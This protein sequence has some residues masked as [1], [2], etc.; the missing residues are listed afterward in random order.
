MVKKMFTGFAAGLVLLGGAYLVQADTI[1][2]TGPGP[3]SFTSAYILSA[4]Q[5]RSQWLAAEFNLDQNYY[6]TGLYGWMW[7]S[8]N[9][10]QNFTISIYGDGGDVP[11]STNL[12]YSN[13][14]TISGADG[15]ADWEGY[16]ITWTDSKG[17]TGQFLSA[18]TYWIAFE[19]RTGN[20]LN[21]YDGGMPYSAPNPLGNGAFNQTGTWVPGDL[22]MGVQIEGDP[23]APVPEPATMLLFGTGLVGLAGSR[24][25]RKK[26]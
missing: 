6:I 23:A 5:Q 9:S 22:S 17:N 20:Y 15:H 1:I 2:D 26:K 12:L 18:G 19:L 16:E 24:F 13:G 3:D 25:R 4:V 21:P 10:G 8:D 14:G 7:N 11:D